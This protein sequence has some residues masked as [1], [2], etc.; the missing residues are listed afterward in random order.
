MMKLIK[1]L[2]PILLIIGLSGCDK[3]FREEFFAHRRCAEINYG[4]LNESQ[5]TNKKENTV[6]QPMRL[7]QEQWDKIRRQETLEVY[8]EVAKMLDIYYPGFW[9]GKDKAFQLAWVE[10]VDNIATKYYGRHDRGTLETMAQV[11]AIIGSDFEQEPKLDFIVKKMKSSQVD[12]PLNEIHDYLRFEILKK[13]YDESG[14]QYNNWRLRGVREGMPKIT[15][16]IPDFD[17][18]WQPDNEQENVW[19]IYKNTIRSERN[20]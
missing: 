20:L 18:E 5:Q 7:T 14:R 13:D 11:C 15:R 17:T 9:Q 6:F 19:S 8:G 16:K 2:I 12:T 10:K 1:I 4:C 3:P